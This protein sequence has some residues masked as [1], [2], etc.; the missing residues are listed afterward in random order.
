MTLEQTVQKALDDLKA[1]SEKAAAAYAQLEALGYAWDKE[2]VCWAYVREGM[3]WDQY[4]QNPWERGP[5][6]APG[7]VNWGASTLIR[8]HPTESPAMRAAQAEAQRRA[9]EFYGSGTY[10]GPGAEGATV[11]EAYRRVMYTGTG[12]A[13][14]TSGTAGA[15]MTSR[16]IDDMLDA[17]R[18]SIHAPSNA[19][20]RRQVEQ[21][22]IARTPPPAPPGERFTATQL[23]EL[24]ERGRAIRQEMLQGL[25]QV[26][27]TPTST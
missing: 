25:A 1:P 9:D 10:I 3:P 21:L 20:I 11:S 4:M 13:S 6:T 26:P 17:M 24:Q 5:S 12:V 18:H 2:N 14:G 16:T 7:A 22:G 23:L 27:R 15:Q 8:R 19:E